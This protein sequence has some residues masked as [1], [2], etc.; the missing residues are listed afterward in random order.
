MLIFF[1]QKLWLFILRFVIFPMKKTRG[2]NTGEKNLN[3]IHKNCRQ[4]PL[5]SLS[6]W[7]TLKNR[8]LV[9]TFVVATTQ[10]CINPHNIWSF[11]PVTCI[12][13]QFSPFLIEVSDK[14]DWSLTFIGF[15]VWLRDIVWAYFILLCF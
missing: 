12:I 11:Y 7:L 6:W 13:F 15:N 14:K 10:G 1:P 9:I 4:Y 3:W 5:L 8:I 2:K